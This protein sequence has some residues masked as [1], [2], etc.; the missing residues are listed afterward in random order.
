MFIPANEIKI[1]DKCVTTKELECFAG[2]FTV[3][4][5]VT[6]TG[7]GDRGYDLV[8]DSGNAMIECGWNCVKKVESEPVGKNHIYIILEHGMVSEILAEKDDVETTIIDLDTNT[9]DEAEASQKSFDVV[10]KLCDEG[11]LKAIL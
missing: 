1:G 2:R 3:G 10:K 11:K 6:I 4:T 7:I 5:V 9:P 8:D